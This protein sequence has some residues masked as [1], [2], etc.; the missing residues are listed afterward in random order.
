MNP[1]YY[2][3]ETVRVHSHRKVERMDVVV[4]HPPATS[5]EVLY[6]KRVIG[7]PGEHIA[8]QKGQL[9][10]DG[11]TV[12][13]PFSQETADF[14]LTASFGWTV[15]PEDTYFLVGDNRQVSKDSRQF[16]V[17]AEDAL[18]GNITNGK[19]TEN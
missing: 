18:V 11:E 12:T 1:T 7:L 19:T 10:I 6:L 15:V 8:Y 14:D 2:E 5:G 9:L 4:F 3:G 17:V 13:D 16:G